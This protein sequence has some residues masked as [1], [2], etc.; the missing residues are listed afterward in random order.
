MA[1]IFKK[2]TRPHFHTEAD[3]HHVGMWACEIFV[4]FLLSAAFFLSCCLV[5]HRVHHHFVVVASCN[6]QYFEIAI[7][8]LLS[9]MLSSPGMKSLSSP[10]SES[11]SSEEKK[12]SRREE[13]SRKREKLQREREGNLTFQPTIKKSSSAISLDQANEVNEPRFNKLYGD[14]K[15]RKETERKD[16]NNYSFKPTI[17]TK[18]KKRS[19]TPE[20]TSKRLFDAPGAG[21]P[22]RSSS[23]DKSKERSFSPQITSRGRSIER[24]GSLSSPSTRLYSQAHTQKESRQALASKISKETSKEL[25][26]APKTNNESNT[27]TQTPSVPMEERMEKYVIAREKRMADLKQKQQA[28]E[29]QSAT[30]KPTSFTKGRSPSA[31]RIRPATERVSPPKPAS[32]PVKDDNAPLTVFDRLSTGASQKSKKKP[33]VHVDKEEKELTFKPNLVSKRAA[34]VSVHTCHYIL[35]CMIFLNILRVFFFPRRTCRML[36]SSLHS[37]RRICLLWL[38]CITPYSCFYVYDA[39]AHISL[40]DKKNHPNTVMYTIASIKKVMSS[41]KKGKLRKK[42]YAE[43]WKKNTH[44]LPLSPLIIAPTLTHPPRVRCLSVCLPAVNM[45]MKF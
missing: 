40:I 36:Y 42:N 8:Y 5:F 1:H 41:A 37:T 3:K 18:G 34:S 39:H 20:G 22:R 16:V 9:C 24:S 43:K 17:T 33:V 31:E 4:V 10:S 11:L 13:V 35:Q 14:A 21:K 6:K 15:K 28:Q 26:F 25:T 32:R 38:T 45:F 44:L 7:I 12:I 30:F 23:V 19:S 27:T 29:S 2:L